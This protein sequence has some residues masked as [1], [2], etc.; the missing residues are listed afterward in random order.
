MATMKNGYSPPSIFL[1]ALAEDHVVLDDS[2]AGAKNLDMLIGLTADTDRA[3]R[4]WAIMLLSQSEINNSRVRAALYSAAL[5]EDEFVRG[6]A[7][8]GIASRD[9]DLALTLLRAE[10]G[11]E[12]IT[13][14]ALEAA[15]QVADRTLVDGL[16]EFAMGDDE[17]GDLA[18]AAIEACSGL[19]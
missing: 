17:L 3:N 10:L 9:R 1:R 4:D 18:R 7:I 5:D 11:R 14:Q 19:P 6:E 2:A 16:R 15:I 13:R 8:L 12:T